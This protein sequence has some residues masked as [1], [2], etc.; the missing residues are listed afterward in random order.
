MCFGYAV[1]NCMACCEILPGRKCSVKS[2]NVCGAADCGRDSFRVNAVRTMPETAAVQS[3][4]FCRRD[5]YVSI[6]AA[7]I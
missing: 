4:E 7:S 2:G 1:G 6:A 3:G 5:A